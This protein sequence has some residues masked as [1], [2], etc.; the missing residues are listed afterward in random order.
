MA[1]GLQRYAQILVLIFDQ[2]LLTY[3]K[4]KAW[5]QGMVGMF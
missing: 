2:T 3:A 5:Y 1:K 4:F